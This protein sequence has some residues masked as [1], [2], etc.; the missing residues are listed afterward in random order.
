MSPIQTVGCPSIHVAPS[1][2]IAMTTMGSYWTRSEIER[3]A[4]NQG[5]LARDNMDYRKPNINPYPFDSAAFGAWWTGW[6]DEDE[7]LTEMAA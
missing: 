7:L 2:G 3:L 5:R 1:A 6:Y 4:Y